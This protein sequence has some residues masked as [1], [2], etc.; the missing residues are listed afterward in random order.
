MISNNSESTT[1]LIDLIPDSR[2]ENA[3]DSLD[4]FMNQERVQTA[5]QH[6]TPNEKYVIKNRYGLDGVESLSILDLSKKMNISREA[7]KRLLSSA[8]NKIRFQL[9]DISSSFQQHSSFSFA[10]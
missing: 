3:Y 9:Q 1:S 5:L 6:L 10:N 8:Q 2:H 4:S 7:V